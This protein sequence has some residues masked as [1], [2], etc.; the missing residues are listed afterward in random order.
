VEG[1]LGAPAMGGRVG[2]RAD[3]LEQLDHRARPA[4]GHDQR[5]RVLVIGLRVDELDLHA[6]DLGRELRECVQLL[7]EVAVS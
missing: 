1:I 3:R 7:L 4:V 6:I 2:E 5:Q